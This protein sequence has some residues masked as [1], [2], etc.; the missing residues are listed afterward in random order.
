DNQPAT[1]KLTFQMPNGL[2]GQDDDPKN[3]VSR[4]LT[5]LMRDSTLLPTFTQAF[6]IDETEG[7]PWRWLGIFVR[8]A[9]DRILFFPGFKDDIDRVRGSRGEQLKFDRQFRID[10]LSL[11]KDRESWHITT[12]RSKDHQG[13][14]PATDLGGGRVLWFGMSLASTEVMREVHQ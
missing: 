4:A 8:S 12:G 1:L 5:S 11:E 3:P 10:H 13:G 14:P 7:Q 2:P 6:L 9:G